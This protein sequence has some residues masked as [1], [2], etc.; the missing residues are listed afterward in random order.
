L[1]VSQRSL[2]TRIPV[3]IA[4]AFL[5]ATAAPAFAGVTAADP[6][7]AETP[8]G[9]EVAAGYLVFAN[10]GAEAVDVIG[11]E[12]PL[13]ERVE[14]HTTDMTGGVARMRPQASLTVPA[15]GELKLEPGGT[16]LMLIRPE[17]L[18]KGG[19]V[20][21]TLELSTGEK[22]S[23]EAMVKPQGGHDHDAGEH[24]HH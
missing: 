9:A 16:H 2:R 21:I 18:S 6:W 24:R 15:G 22:L 11:A 8:P 7:V 5:L 10:D 14:L 17:P 1:N 3:A 13:C 23:V 19:M 4:A 20:P 12:S